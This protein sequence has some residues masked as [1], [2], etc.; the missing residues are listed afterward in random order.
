MMRIFTPDDVELMCITG[1]ERDGSALLVK[2]K[3]MG[4]MPMKA[5]IRPEE[6]RKLMGLLDLPTV[7]FLMTLPFRRGVRVNRKPEV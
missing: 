4:A 2:G 5:H 7:L 6:I 3:I 1:L